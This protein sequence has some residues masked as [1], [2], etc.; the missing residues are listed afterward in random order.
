[1]RI[2][3]INPAIL[4]MRPLGAC[5]Q[6]RLHNIHDLQ[7]M[8]HTVHL[9]TRTAPHLSIDESKAFYEEREISADILSAEYPRAAPKRLFDP[10]FLDGASWEY[11][12]PAFS[13]FVQHSVKRWRPDLVW[14]HGS[15]LWAAARTARSTGV[16]V[17]I[18]SVNYEADHFLD[19]NPLVI[20]IGRWLRYYGKTLS[21]KRAMQY[22]AVLAAITPY[23]HKL[24]RLL[25]EHVH[26]LPLRALPDILEKGAVSSQTSDPLRVLFM[27]ST[28][29]VTHNRNALDFIVQQVAPKV[30]QL[31]P[32]QFQFH[33]AGSKIPKSVRDSAST[34]DV[35]FDDYVE[36]LDS[37]LASMQIAAMPSLGGS[38]MQQKVFEVIARGLPTVTHQRALAGYAFVPD[39]DVLV[40]SDADDFA[41]KIVALKDMGL[42]AHIAAGG[43]AMSEALFGRDQMDTYVHAILQAAVKSVD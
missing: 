8:G 37:Y 20:G 26:L 41:A 43:R 24:Y 32:N 39:R 2:L 15:Y 17:V 21:E 36:D 19:E 33:I 30:R 16:P 1:M 6:D 12:D 13:S 34:G 7:R 14:C 10:A 25:G 11:G 9:I 40:G 38:G 18:R 22:S 35:I 29:N 42:R 31:A 23:E 3:V 5:E 4:R 27:A 28:Y